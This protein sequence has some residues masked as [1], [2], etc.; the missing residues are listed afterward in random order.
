MC[1]AKSETSKSSAHH[2]SD[3][4]HEASKVIESFINENTGLSVK[5]IAQGFSHRQNSFFK[6]GFEDQLRDTY[7]PTHLPHR[8]K[9]VKEV[10]HVLS[11]AIHG[12][13][14]SHLIVYGKTGT[15]KTAVVRQILN[16]L[17]GLAR[18]G[19]AITPL[20]VDCSRADTHYS[21]LRTLANDLAT[22]EDGP[23]AKRFGVKLGTN[24]LYEALRSLLERRGGLVVLVLDEVDRVIRNSGDTVVFTLVNLNGEL[25]NAKVAMIATTNNN[26]LNE[27]LE[28]PTLSRLNEERIHFPPYNQTQLLD[29]LKARAKEVFVEDGVDHAALAR[30]AVYGAQEHGDA[31]KA[32]AI[33]RVAA[34]EAD[35]EGASRITESHIDLAKAHLERDMVLE[36]IQ[37]LPLQQKAVLYTIAFMTEVGKGTPQSNMIYTNYAQLTSR[38]GMS[39]LHQRSIRN[40]IADFRTLGLLQ[41]TLNNRGRGGGVNLEAQLTAPPELVLHAIEQDEVFAPFAKAREDRR[42]QQRTL[43]P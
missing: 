41:T 43:F 2:V 27:K 20:F 12:R 13:A 1:V 32:L 29:I 15:G 16:T 10:L 7:V 22:L 3:E 17:P 19:V 42:I 5:E 38:M 14:P 40:Y 28:Q 39:P 18:P 8:E 25:K 37:S 21:V 35:Q 31:R 30:C 23:N 4:S 24:E 11:P 36:S 6:P 26:L 34:R 33:L 9:E